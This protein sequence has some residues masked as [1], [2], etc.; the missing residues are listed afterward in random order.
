MAIHTSNT[1]TRLLE[2]VARHDELWAAWPPE[3]ASAEV[4]AEV[5]AIE[6]VIIAMPVFSKEGLA[7]KM[8]IIE[9]VELFDAD[10]IVD[11]ILQ[12]DKERIGG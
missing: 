8:R 2:L 10:D 3:G 6:P 12:L 9:R 5:C 11:A 7:A 1:D 4:L